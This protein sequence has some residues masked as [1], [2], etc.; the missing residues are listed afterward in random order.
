VHRVR[1]L[2][3]A[4]SGALADCASVEGDHP[5]VEAGLVGVDPDG[6]AAIPRRPE[7]VPRVV[8]TYLRT[9]PSP[10]RDRIPPAQL[11]IFSGGPKR[12]GGSPPG[13]SWGREPA[14]THGQQRSPADSRNRS[15][16]TVSGVI[17][18]PCRYMACK[19]SA[20]RQ[21]GQG[22]CQ[23]LA[24]KLPE[25]M[26]CH[27]TRRT[28]TPRLSEPP[29]CGDV[30]LG[31]VGEGDAWRPCSLHTAEATGSK[32]V[33][34]TSTNTLPEPLRDVGCQ[35]IASKPPTVVAEA[36]EAL[37]VSGFLRIPCPLGRRPGQFSGQ[38]GFEP[39]TGFLR[40]PRLERR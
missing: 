13:P 16:T 39:S 33:T 21:V 31:V 19:R 37:P 30:V 17:E 12:E 40:H 5:P 11:P 25:A 22:L 14:V 29:S 20:A 18:P 36:L 38:V 28:T 27:A 34:P 2:V 6:V 35:Q 10:W 26:P 8:L 3:T 7:L 32:P 23:R 15:S 1:R 9:A 4:G 24:R